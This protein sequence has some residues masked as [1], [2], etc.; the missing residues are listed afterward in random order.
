MRWRTR[1]LRLVVLLA[2]ILGGIVSVRWFVMPAVDE[3]ET[4]DA[5]IVFAG[6]R[7][8]RLPEAVHL[9]EVGLAPVL[10]IMNGTDP[11]WEA[12]N[13]LCAGGQAFA[14]VCP[15]PD[16]DN[17]R[18]EAQT[19]AALATDSGWDQL[20]LVTSD[21]HSH[22]ANLLLGRCFD[23]EVARVAAH[24]EIGFLARTWSILREIAATPGV[25]FANEC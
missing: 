3:P 6:G 15:S 23:G 1:K 14:V 11:V 2:V 9:V 17:T 4:S 8:E 5:V 21:Y 18:G 20:T 19:A 24:G 10:V 13:E 7:G 12:A 16:P 25:L 22:R